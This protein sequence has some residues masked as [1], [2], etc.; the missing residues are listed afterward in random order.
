ME[1]LKLAENTQI[2]PKN[3][4]KRE[5]KPEKYTSIA[6]Q[7]ALSEIPA[8]KGGKEREKEKEKLSTSLEEKAKKKREVK[9]RE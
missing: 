2:G 3:R 5:C 1:Q 4:G 7:L 8:G 6:P 9:S